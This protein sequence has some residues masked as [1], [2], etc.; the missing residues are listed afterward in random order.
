MKRNLLFNQATAIGKR[1]A[2][3]LTMLLIVGIG[4]MWGAEEA[5]TISFANA[6][7]RVSQT[8]S[9]QVWK[10]GDVTFTNY[11]GAST[12]DVVNNT[13]PVRLYASSSITITA[14]GNITKIVATASSSS[15]AT[16]L[17]N[18][19]TSGATISGSVVT[20]IPSTSS[21]SYNIAKLS[22][23]VRLNSIAITYEVAASCDKKVTINKGSEN[24]GKFTLD[25]S[26]EQETCD[27]LTIL[28]TPTPNDHYSVG[29]V[30]AT[31]PTTGGAPT[32]TDNGNDTWSVTYAA[33]STGSSIINVTFKAAPR[34]TITLSEAGSTRNPS[35]TF[36]V[37]DSYTLPSSTAE[38]G[39]KTFVGWST[40]TIDN[41]AEKPT[42]NFHEP[43]ASITLGATNTFYAVF[44]ESGGTPTTTWSKTDIN[45]IKS[46]DEVV[47]TMTIGGVTYAMSNDK[48]T[49]AAP[50][51]I[52]MTIVNNAITNDI[53]DTYKWNISNSSGTL[54]IYPNGKTSAWLYCTNTNNGVRVGTNT[55]K[56]FTIDASS[57]Y[58]K[59]I[60]T[61]RYIGVYTYNPDWRCYTGTS[62]TNIDNQTLAFY[63]KTTT[64]GYQNYT[65]S[66]ATET[67]VCVIPKCG[68]D[69][70]GT[71]LVVIEWF[72]T[73]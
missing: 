8:T 28:V 51:A 19:I 33:N 1:L 66:C 42:S 49:S 9:Q 3:V 4:Q 34:A 56:T 21:T 5:V 43:D 23:Q 16:A 46:T 60:A 11:K 18:S 20:I 48:G 59:N 55:N 6:N 45:N 32:I 24:N 73:F 68:G 50:T 36:Y 30:T 57:G 70:G 29:S 58:L 14:P 40:T 15:Y 47:I 67:T 44:A 37:G 27:G 12:S 72:A 25:K 17:K 26:G 41:S 53:L 65:T 39:D 71:W 61:N 35:G 62:G 52:T 13:N 63:A 69:G 64:A 38:C 2:M 22:A 31:T 10:N 54:T 7:Q